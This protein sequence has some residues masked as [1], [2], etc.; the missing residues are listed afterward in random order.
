[1]ARSSE[2]LRS[3]PSSRGMQLFAQPPRSM[4]LWFLAK[5]SRNCLGT[6][7]VYGKRCTR[8]QQRA[9]FLQERFRREFEI[10][11]RPNLLALSRRRFAPEKGVNLGRFLLSLYRDFAKPPSLVASFCF[12]QRCT[13]NNDPR[14]ILWSLG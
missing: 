13:R 14:C 5:L 9:P 7:Q 12:R 1:M 8:L 4:P 3:S 6:C 11:N 10:D 2:K